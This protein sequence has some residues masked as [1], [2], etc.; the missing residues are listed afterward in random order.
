M[1]ETEKPI[2]GDIWAWTD[3]NSKVLELFSRPEIWQRHPEATASLLDFMRLMCD[4]PF[5]FRRIGLPRLERV[6]DN[7]NAGGRWLHTLM[8]VTADLP[9][10][11]LMLGIRFHDGRTASNVY[12]T[13]N[14]VQ[15]R[16]GGEILTID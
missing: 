13:G 2:D 14:Y 11:L 12:L 1:V 6:E 7:G 10:G 15:F 4:G 5:I 8:H 16:L 9:A 3:D